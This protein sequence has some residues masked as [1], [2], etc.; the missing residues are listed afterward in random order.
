MYTTNK[1]RKLSATPNTNVATGEGNNL[2]LTNPTSLSLPSALRKKHARKAFSV[3][4]TAIFYS[5]NL[6]LMIKIINIIHQSAM[7]SGVYTTG[8]LVWQCRCKHVKWLH[9]DRIIRV[10]LQQ[11]MKK[12]HAEKEIPPNWLKRA[13]ALTT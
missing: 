2:T 10:A 4:E 12:Y 11:H 6:C 1:T 3:F 7:C 8:F 5:K 13:Y 9:E